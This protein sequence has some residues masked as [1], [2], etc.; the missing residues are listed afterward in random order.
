MSGTS[1]SLA[2]SYEKLRLSPSI[3]SINSAHSSGAGS[4][5]GEATGLMVEHEDIILLTNDV[6][7]FRGILAKL[8]RFFTDYQAQSIE[9]KETVKV[10]VHERLGEVLRVL[11]IILEKY[12]PIQ[13]TQL[14][15]AAG[16]LIQQVKGNK[17]LFQEVMISIPFQL[18]LNNLAILFNQRAIMMMKRLT[19][20]SFSKQS[21]IWHTHLVAGMRTFILLPCSSRYI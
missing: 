11:R 7:N 13:S 15:M 12:P 1:Q 19:L 10:Q 20:A 2:L 3:N 16:K 21:I 4:S 17:K 5:G 18:K 8:R 6:K 14:L 9:G